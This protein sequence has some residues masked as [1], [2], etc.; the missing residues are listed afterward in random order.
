MLRRAALGARLE[1]RRARQALVDL[2]ALPLRRAPHTALL[3]RIWELRDNLT[4][5]DAAY[6]AVA[7][8]LGAPLLTADRKLHGATGPRCPIE[9]LR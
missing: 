9:L 1:T 6:V 2:A 3:E 8:A 4:T 7:E 5:Y